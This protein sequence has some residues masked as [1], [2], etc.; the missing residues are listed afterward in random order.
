MFFYAQIDENDRVVGVSALS[1]KITEET[2][3]ELYHFMVQ[4]DNQDS[5]LVGKVYQ[6][7]EFVYDK[8][9]EIEDEEF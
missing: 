7:G 6:D 4:I 5:S 8:K 3:P 2:H 1:A 9:S